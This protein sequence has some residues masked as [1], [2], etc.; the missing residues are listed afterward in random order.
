MHRLILLLL[1]TCLAAPAVARTCDGGIV[2]RDDNGNGRRDRG[3]QGLAG[4]QV[5][6][7]TRIVTTDANGRYRL[8]DVAGGTTFVIKPAGFDVPTGANGL[9]LFWRNVP[10]ARGAQALRYGGLKAARAASCDFALRPS[11]AAADAPLDLLVFSDPQVQS[12]TE[13]GY[14]RRA[15]VDHARRHDTAALGITLGD[16]VNDTLDLYPALNAETASL[17]LPWLHVPGNHDIDLDAERDADA[18]S[19]FRHIYG[20]DTYAWSQGNATFVVLDDVIHMRGQRPAYIGGF[21]DDQFAFLEAFLPT[22]SKERLLVI[23]VHIPFFEPTP[24]KD[25]FRD[26]DRERLFA[27]L[28]DFPHVLLLSGHSHAQRHW[29]HDASTGWHG[30]TPLHEYN[31]GAACGSYWSGPLDARGLP[32]A[33]MADGTANGYATLRVTPAAGYALA[34]QAV[35]AADDPAFTRAMRLHAP[36]TLRRGAYPA[37]GV[38]A[39]VFMGEA[40]TRVEFRVD[41]GEWQPMTRTERADPWLTAQN[42]LDDAATAL[43]SFDR[44]PEP[45]ASP[46]LWRASIPTRLAAGEHRIE[47]RAFDRWQGEQ[48]ASTTYTLIEVDAP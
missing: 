35:G 34:W 24:G 15:I 22:V 21:R 25:E 27:L 38:F 31:V 42:A 44:T 14:Y 40:D 37:W 6:D 48:R 16:I 20:P 4:I 30:A 46:H 13:V 41:D 5:S 47:V 23:G 32:D 33:T 29:R 3:E 8:R 18:L 9:P 39:N 26:A 12:T 17:G 45:E 11:T 10:P 19:S 28:R 36:K 1:C 2:W 43:R 7:G